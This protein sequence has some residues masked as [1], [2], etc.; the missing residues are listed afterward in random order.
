MSKFLTFFFFIKKYHQ[1]QINFFLEKNQSYFCIENPLNPPV[2]GRL[3]PHTPHWGLRIDTVGIRFRTLRI[4]SDKK[5]LAIFYIFLCQF[6]K[7]FNYKIE[8]VSKTKNRKIV[9]S[10]VTEH[11]ETYWNKNLIWPLLRGWVCMS[12]IGTWS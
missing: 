7:Y 5:N 3:R 6:F 9:F 10:Q 12:L 2:R 1:N 4:F 11:C 8:Y